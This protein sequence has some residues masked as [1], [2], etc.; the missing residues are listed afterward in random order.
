MG[1]D[2]DMSVSPGPDLLN[3]KGDEMKNRGSSPGSAAQLD[4]QGLPK[5]QPKGFK[6]QNAMRAQLVKKLHIDAKTKQDE[7]IATP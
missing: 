6:T 7:M 5:K 4:D 3:I 1:R 2:K